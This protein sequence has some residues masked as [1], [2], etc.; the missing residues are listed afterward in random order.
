M[1]P[2]ERTQNSLRVSGLPPIKSQGKPRNGFVLLEVTQK[3][4]F[5]CANCETSYVRR[6]LALKL[7]TNDRVCRL[8]YQE[9]SPEPPDS[10]PARCPTRNRSCR[11]LGRPKR[12]A[13]ASSRTSMSSPE[14]DARHSIRSSQTVQAGTSLPYIRRRSVRLGRRW[15]RPPREVRWR[16]RARTGRSNWTS[17]RW[18]AVRWVPIPRRSDG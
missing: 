1:S 17:N 12:Q 9:L 15:C 10:R 5:R 13:H 7:K 3:H 2:R 8:C 18:A 4:R 6:A 14:R 16:C 11:C